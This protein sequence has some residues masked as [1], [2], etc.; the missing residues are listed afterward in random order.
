MS[1][2]TDRQKLLDRID[3]KITIKGNSIFVNDILVRCNGI[4]KIS[5]RNLEI[6][7]LRLQK[8]K[9][10][11]TLES[12]AKIY[13]ISKERVRKIEQDTILKIKNQYVSYIMYNDTIK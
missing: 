3:F 4:P 5:E 10:V 2:K 8:D 9:H 6:V 13:S 12:I 7:K 11:N 1:F